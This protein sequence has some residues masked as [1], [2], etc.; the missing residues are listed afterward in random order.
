M[1]FLFFFWMAVVFLCLMAEVLVV[2]RFA[3][4]LDQ[5]MGNPEWTTTED[6]RKRLDRIVLTFRR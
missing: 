4:K 6:E 2:D 3:K 5:I 1:T